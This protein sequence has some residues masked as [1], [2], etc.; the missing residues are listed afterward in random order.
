MG[1]LDMCSRREAKELVMQGR[2][3]VNGQLATEPSQ[4]V[5]PHE[6]AIEVIGESQDSPLLALVVH[7]PLGYVA[8][9]PEG[10]QVPTIR[11]VKKHNMLQPDSSSACLGPDGDVLPGFAP[12]G[13]LDKNSTGLMIFSKS[14]VLA[15]KLIASESTL[16]KEYIVTV[17]KANHI[18][19][20]ERNR[21]V[22]SLPYSHLNLD[23]LRKGGGVLAGETRPL[24]PA[25]V[26]W[27]EEGSVLR[28]I[29][30]EGMKHQIRR[31]MREM[32]GYHV[33]KLMRTRVGPVKIEDM[34]P[35]KWRALTQSEIDLILA[36]PT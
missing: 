27:I 15:K 36:T 19:K 13:R 25:F 2:V 16:E 30:T 33:T 23:I 21:G 34:P 14:G 3:L 10:D 5:S 7:K 29:L 17:S 22:Q 26:E 9:H 6:T 18:S 20:A 28:I 31:S 11:L 8:A 12:A 35:G 32:L 24:K 4:K 1:E